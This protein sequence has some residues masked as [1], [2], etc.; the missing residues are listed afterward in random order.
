MLLQHPTE[1]LLPNSESQ[2]NDFMPSSPNCP[3]NNFNTSQSIASIIYLTF[4]RTAFNCMLALSRIRQHSITCRCSFCAL[5][6]P[7]R[8]R[9]PIPLVRSHSYISHAPYTQRSLA[10]PLGRYRQNVIGYLSFIWTLN[11]W[12][13]NVFNVASYSSLPKVLCLLMQNKNW[14]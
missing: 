9:V 3:I 4:I 10:R 1:T 6:P 13:E 5:S 12:K 2:A 8:A 14:A 7:G 11:Y